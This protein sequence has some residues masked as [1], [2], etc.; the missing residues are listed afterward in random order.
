MVPEQLAAQ[1]R[2]AALLDSPPALE[3]SADVLGTLSTLTPVYVRRASPGERHMSAPRAELLADLE[4]AYGFTPC[5]V[6]AVVT[7][8]PE[9]RILWPQS[10]KPT[11]GMVTSM[12]PLD[13]GIEVAVGGQSGA[14]CRS[15]DQRGRLRLPPGVLQAAGLA[16]GARVIIARASGQWLLVPAD[17]V[18]IRL[19]R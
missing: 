11:A 1:R 16:A 9:R 17:R 6:E 2:T 10:D 15:L 14:Y 4:P 12:R 8:D 13:R 7:I 18:G 3:S 5:E 19:I